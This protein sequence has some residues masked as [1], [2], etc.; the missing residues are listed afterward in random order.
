MAV[1]RSRRCCG[2]SVDYA[3]MFPPASL[4]IGDAMATYKRYSRQRGRVDRRNV[5]R[6]RGSL[7]TLTP[8]SGQSASS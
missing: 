2:E 1:D 4:A 6:C 5:R 8:R 7:G 3:G